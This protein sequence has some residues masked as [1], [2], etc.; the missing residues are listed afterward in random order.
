MLTNEDSNKGYR[1]TFVGSGMDRSLSR[2]NFAKF[3]LD[4]VESNDW[5]NEMPVASDFAG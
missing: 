3:M 1:V 2:A 4:L 5:M